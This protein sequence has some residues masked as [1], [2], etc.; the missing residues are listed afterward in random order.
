MFTRTKRIL[1]CATAG[2]MLSTST[3]SATVTIDFD[4]LPAMNNSPGSSVPIA[5]QLS[6]QFV[7]INGASFQSQAEYVAVVDHN[8]PPGCGLTEC[9]TVS[10][11]NIIGGVRSD[12]TLSYGT[13]ITISFFVPSN[14]TTKGIT[15]VVSIRG[16][17]VPLAGAT[18]T[19][20][21]FNAAGQSIG[22]A[23]ANDTSDGL[24]LSINASGIHSLMLTQNSASGTIDGTIGFDNLE[25]NEV[26]AVPVPAGVWL[27]GSGLLGLIRIARRKKV[28]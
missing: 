11:P 15:D 2:I 26:T 21:A 14:P 16:D 9:L 24:S 12:G 28:A 8:T 19:M 18:A 1:M 17:M 10:M 3:Q 4:S 23:T 22:T 5:N 27:F 25:F 7:T 20:E 13:P 6:D